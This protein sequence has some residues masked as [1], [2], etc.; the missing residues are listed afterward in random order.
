M[1]EG[2]PGVAIVI[3]PNPRFL[4]EDNVCCLVCEVE[5]GMHDICRFCCLVQDIAYGLVGSV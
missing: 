5:E 1:G 4:D 3:K 2:C